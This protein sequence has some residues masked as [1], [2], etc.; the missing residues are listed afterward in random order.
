MIIEVIIVSVGKVYVDKI[1]RTMGACEHLQS[2]VL[3][4]LWIGRVCGVEEIRAAGPRGPSS[5]GLTTRVRQLVMYKARINIW[6]LYRPPPEV[7]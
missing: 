7:T 4:D 6:N 5:G 1:I 3:V 2:V